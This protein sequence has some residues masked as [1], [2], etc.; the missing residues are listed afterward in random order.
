MTT[1]KEVIFREISNGQK[2]SSYSTHALHSYPAQCIPQIPQFF[3]EKNKPKEEGSIVLDPFCGAGTVLLEGLHNGWNS[4]GVD[5]NPI[6]SL[7][8]KVKTTPIDQK[9]LTDSL[10]KISKEFN[11][12]KSS[13]LIKPHFENI[14]Y[15]FSDQVVD[16]LTKIKH[17][18]NQIDNEDVND[19]FK[20]IF[21]SILKRTSCADPRMYV[22]VRSKKEIHI[23]P[24]WVWS[25]FSEKAKN[26]ICKIAELNQILKNTKTASTVINADINKLKLEK[27]YFD[28]IIT[29]PPYISAQKYVRSTRLEAYWLDIDKKTQLKINKDTIGSER[30]DHHNYNELILTGHNKIDTVLNQIYEKN[31]IRAG[32]TSKYFIDMECVLKKL[33]CI[34]KE[35]GKFILI[36]GDNTVTGLTVPTSKF[37]MEISEIIGFK[38]KTIL[39]DKINSRGMITKRNAAASMITHEW[40]IE[41]L[42]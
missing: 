5:I 26:G 25:F 16:E 6:A 13:D 27:N 28:M 39:V 7:I 18:L 12:V 10:D 15:W 35:N 14:S 9:I 23:N 8:S 34:L 21:S 40:V 1:P 29:S 3:L 41:F 2:G 11:S 20:I 37:L 32:I 30:I 36:I 17:S 31:Q 24:R 22:P 33:Y 38:T 4:F 42:K 19:F